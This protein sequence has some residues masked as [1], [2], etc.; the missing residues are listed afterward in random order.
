MQH[1]GGGPGANAFGEFGPA[2]DAQHD[3]YQALEQWVEKGV[4]PDKII[5]KK[6][7]SEA[8]HTQGVKM[9]RPLCPYPESAKYKGAGDTDDTA[10]FACSEKLEKVTDS[11][12]KPPRA[13]HSPEPKYS[14]SAREQ[15]IEGIVVVAITIGSNGQVVDP[16]VVRPLEPSLDA[17]AIETVKTWKFAPATKNGRPVAVMMN[18]EISYNLRQ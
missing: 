4:A 18:V 10:N 12:V 14:K 17:I 7:V 3:L 1:C 9:T 15:G 11:S 5:A 2:G 16:K 8:D 13:L 6:F